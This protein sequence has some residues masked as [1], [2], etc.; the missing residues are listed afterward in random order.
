ML[1]S[2][3]AA[4]AAVLL[5]GASAAEAAA[6]KDAKGKFI[7]CPAPAAAKAAGYTADAK[8]NC[9]DASGKMVKKTMCAAAPSAA[10]AAGGPTA[11]LAEGPQCKKGKRCGNACIAA[12]EACHK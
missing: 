1:R 7:A 3:T 10:T 6:C 2:F 9:H 4:M 5:M 12:T 11:K 8:G